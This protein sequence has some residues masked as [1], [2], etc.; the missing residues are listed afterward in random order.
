MFKQALKKVAQQATSFEEI[1]RV[2][3]DYE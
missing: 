1:T 3:A 2:I